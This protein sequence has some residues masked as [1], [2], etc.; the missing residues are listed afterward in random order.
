ML[1]STRKSATVQVCGSRVYGRATC[2]GWSQI[3]SVTS[4]LGR[5]LLF[6]LYFSLRENLQLD[7]WA[8]AVDHSCGEVDA[9]MPL[10]YPQTMY[11]GDCLLELVA[12]RSVQMQGVCML[13]PMRLRPRI[14]SGLAF[15]PVQLLHRLLGQ[16]SGLRDLI[17]AHLS[18]CGY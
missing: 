16:A 1:C 9:L 3:L 10:I 17:P 2:Q 8:T 7:D 4:D 11:H 5:R 15:L 12:T 18:F 6:K 13:R 14:H